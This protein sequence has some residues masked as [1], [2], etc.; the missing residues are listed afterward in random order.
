MISES[1]F[2]IDSDDSPLRN[3]EITTVMLG[4]QSQ[5]S[6]PLMRGNAA[7][8]V[9]SLGAH[10]PGGFLKRNMDQTGRKLARKRAPTRYIGNSVETPCRSWLERNY[11]ILPNCQIH[12]IPVHPRIAGQPS[13][14]D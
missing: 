3:R 1:W 7:I 6:V 13:G 5:V 10:A 11:A 2:A 4:H 9:I 12:L 8:G 14:S